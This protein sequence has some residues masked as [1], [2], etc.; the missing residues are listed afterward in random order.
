MIVYTL[1]TFALILGSR[2][3]FGNVSR[4]LLPAFP[5]AL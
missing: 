1:L 5:P 4:Y 2:Q 3:I